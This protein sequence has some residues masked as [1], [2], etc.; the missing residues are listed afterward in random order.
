MDR[1]F[2]LI[3]KTFN[4]KLE[5]CST[6]Y[7]QIDHYVYFHDTRLKVLKRKD[8]KSDK[9]G[10]EGHPHEVGGQGLQC[11][12]DKFDDDNDESNVGGAKFVNT[13]HTNVHQKDNQV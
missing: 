8:K 10:G 13:C 2:V 12:D 11:R 1:K 6:I 9:D 7:Q 4:L 5:P 3:Q